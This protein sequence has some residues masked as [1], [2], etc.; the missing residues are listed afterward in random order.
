MRRTEFFQPCSCPWNDVCIALRGARS[1]VSLPGLTSWVLFNK[2][3]VVTWS[4]SEVFR[5]EMLRYWAFAFCQVLS[6]GIFG[7]TAVSDL[8]TPHGRVKFK[9]CGVV[10]LFNLE[11]ENSSTPKP[12]LVQC[13]FIREKQRFPTSILLLWCSMLVL[14]LLKMVVCSFFFSKIKLSPLF[15]TSGM[16]SKKEVCRF[17]YL[18]YMV[19]KYRYFICPNRERS[20]VTMKLKCFDLG[21]LACVYWRPSRRIHFSGTHWSITV[22]KERKFTR[23]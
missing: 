6:Y 5:W 11:G 21:N 2:S 18:I 9:G 10:L 4:R 15:M 19:L 17:E 13:S 16:E 22:V 1:L 23:K 8:Q 20:W 7:R 14:L 12:R 3:N